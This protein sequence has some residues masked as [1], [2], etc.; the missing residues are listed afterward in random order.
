MKGKP[1]RKT[2]KSQKSELLQHDTY[3]TQQIGLLKKNRL[4]Y[5]N[6]SKIKLEKNK[7]KTEME[8]E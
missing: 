4:S 1:I 3:N 6:N 5:D 7:Y 2:N 8:E